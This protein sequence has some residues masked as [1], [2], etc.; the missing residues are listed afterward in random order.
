M[1]IAAAF[2]I[3]GETMKPGIDLS[4]GAKSPTGSRARLT[5]P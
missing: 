4:G 5:E 3:G 2:E 1:V